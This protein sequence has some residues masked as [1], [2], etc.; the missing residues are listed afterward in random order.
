[1]AKTTWFAGESVSD[2]L[3]VWAPLLAVVG[4]LTNGFMWMGEVVLDDG[5]S[6]HA[7]KHCDTRRY[8]HLD[9]HHN[10]WAYQHRQGRSMYRQVSLADALTEA[11]ASW[12]GLAFGPSAE[13]GALIAQVIGAARTREPQP[14]TTTTETVAVEI[15]AALLERARAR[16]PS[17][18]RPTDRATAE[19]ALVLYA[20]DRELLYGDCRGPLTDADASFLLSDELYQTGRVQQDA[21]Q[22]GVTVND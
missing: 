5:R 17:G 15:D 6:L 11:F 1:M 3:P 2:G 9:T 21:I 8:V 20:L 14:R 19:H 13:E 22:Q 7:Y 12:D 4:S 10:A 16:V 18:C